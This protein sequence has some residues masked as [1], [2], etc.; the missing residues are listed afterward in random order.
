[1]GLMTLFAHTDLSGTII[2]GEDLSMARML[3]S[4]SNMRFAEYSQH[5]GYIPA[6]KVD[7]YLF[8]HLCH[9]GQ[10]YQVLH[11]ENILMDHWKDAT[12]W[13]I[14]KSN[15]CQKGFHAPYSLYPLL[16]YSQKTLRILASNILFHTGSQ[17]ILQISISCSGEKQVLTI[18]LAMIWFSC[19]WHGSLVDVE[20]RGGAKTSL[21]FDKL[22]TRAGRQT[23][24]VFETNF[25]EEEMEL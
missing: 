4:L 3:F 19:L 6:E 12:L 25:C 7:S 18:C 10:R 17:R 13:L 9:H 16:A 23:S 22:R 14:E 21:E 5:W 15:Q 8:L 11:V 2:S 24:P 20:K 1:M